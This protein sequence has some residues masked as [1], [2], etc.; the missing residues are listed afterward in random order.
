MKSSSC[1]P[2]CSS[3]QIL[4]SCFAL[5]VL[6]ASSHAASIQ[7]RTVARPVV[8]GRLRATP[9]ENAD[10]ERT[11]RELFSEAGCASDQL[12]EQAVKHAKLPNV[13]CTVP[14]QTDSTIIVG[15]HFDRVAEGSGVIDNWS[16]AAM[17]PSLLQSLMGH[18]R[19]H[20]L[21]FIGFTD[22]EKGLVGSRFYVDRL[23]KE[24][25]KKISAMINLDSLA[26]GPTELEVERG[27][28]KLINALVS[29]AQSLQLPLSGMNIHN[30]GRSDSD[31]FQDRRIPSVM[32]HS[33]TQETFPILHS[34]RDQLEAVRWDDYYNTYRLLAAYVAYLDGMLDAPE[35]PKQE[36]GAVQ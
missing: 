30:V 22:E 14:G 8:E 24:E 21:I 25:K 29:V 20:R 5:L 4:L 3:R 1:S 7:Y 18:P 28:K 33:I 19:R 23:S 10:R 35:Q 15:A 11:L 26:A 6:A 34:K 9:P 31:S 36:A 27:D 2:R 12:Q 16:G 13:I 17:L 32:V